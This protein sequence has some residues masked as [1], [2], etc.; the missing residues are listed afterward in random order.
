MKKM[1][2]KTVLFNDKQSKTTHLNT[3]T[4]NNKKNKNPNLLGNDERKINFSLSVTVSKSDDA[5]DQQKFDKRSKT[6][7]KEIGQKLD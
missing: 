4:K 6:L 3:Q 1:K 5:C 2:T 7:K